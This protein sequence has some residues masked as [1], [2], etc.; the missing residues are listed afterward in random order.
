MIASLKI[1]K[2]NVALFTYILLPSS[3]EVLMTSVIR[4]SEPH[5]ATVT[6]VEVLRGCQDPSHSLP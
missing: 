3:R 1:S 2:I 4:L 6:Q 5:T